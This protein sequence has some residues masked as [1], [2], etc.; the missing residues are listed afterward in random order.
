MVGVASNH[1]LNT[2]V[3]DD[4]NKNNWAPFV[5]LEPG[6][7]GRFIITIFIEAFTTN[8]IRQFA[9]LWQAIASTENLK[10]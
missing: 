6:S 4:K 3:V 9:I 10:I 1:V 8:I 7:C 5:A 2:E